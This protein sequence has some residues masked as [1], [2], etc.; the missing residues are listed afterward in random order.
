MRDTQV[1]R[2]KPWYYITLAEFSL[3]I[4]GISVQRIIILPLWAIA[5]T[6]SDTNNMSVSLFFDTPIFGFHPAK[7][8]SL[9]VL[10]MWLFWLTS[11][12]SSLLEKH[13]NII[14]FLLVYGLIALLFKTST[15]FVYDILVS[16]VIVGHY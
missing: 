14:K 6:L 15:T 2:H 10:L 1:H 9:I 7:S 13:H 4:V 8:M 3:I 12:I 5:A 11:A 16:I